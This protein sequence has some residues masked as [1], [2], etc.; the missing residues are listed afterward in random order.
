LLQLI[1]R[2]SRAIGKHY[3]AKTIF[4]LNAWLNTPFKSPCPA[5]GSNPWPKDI[6]SFLDNSLSEMPK[7]E[8]GSGR[9]AEGKD[10]EM[11]GAL[12]TT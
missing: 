10:W 9:E 1:K 5:S 8:E 6:Q 2:I 12:E 11:I 7:M 3:N 4:I